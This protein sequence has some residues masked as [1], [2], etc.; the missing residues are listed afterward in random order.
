VIFNVAAFVFAASEN[1]LTEPNKQ[2]ATEKYL[3]PADG[4]LL[5]A[6]S[7]CGQFHPN[8]TGNQ[9]GRHETGNA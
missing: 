9:N 7:F 1:N 5:I 6:T 3:Q 2:L 4:P 8:S